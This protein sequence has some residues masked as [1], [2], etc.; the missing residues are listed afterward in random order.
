M[1]FIF[2]L[3]VKQI[4]SKY[5]FTFIAIIVGAVLGYVYYAKVG[6]VSGTCMITSSPYISTAYGGM[7]GLFVFWYV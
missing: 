1:N 3:I 7:T 5:K 2:A 4:L 6:C